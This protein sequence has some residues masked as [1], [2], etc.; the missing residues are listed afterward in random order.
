MGWGSSDSPFLP[1]ATP[2]P[3]LP[4]SGGG[5]SGAPSGG[6][7]RC[8]RNARSS[9]LLRHRLEPLCRVERGDDD[10]LIAGAAA[11]IAGDRDAH[12]LFGR[13]GI[14]AQELEQG[15]QH[16]RGAEAALQAVI[17]MKRLLQR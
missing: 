13:I 5:R 2:S 10:V 11:Q 7:M 16:P 17:L 14:V 4:L 12:L 9:F 15:G 3:T 1:P 8:R 6:R